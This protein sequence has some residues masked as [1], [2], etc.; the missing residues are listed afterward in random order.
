M[1]RK[2]ITSMDVA[3]KAGVSQS[4]V[5][6]V[7]NKKYNASFSRE[8]VEKVEAA[9]R[10]L[11]Y[12]LEKKAVKAGIKLKKTI[13]VVC[14]SLSNP[15]YNMLLEGIEQVAQKHNYDIFIC[16]TRRSLMTEEKYLKKV[17]KLLPSGMIY[18]SMPGFIQMV[19]AMSEKIPTVFVG[20]KNV[21]LNLDAIELDSRKPGNMVAKYLI[22]LGHN[23]V[24]YI[25]TPLSERQPARL[26]RMQ[27]FLEAFEAA[28]FKETVYVKST[29]LEEDER[30]QKTDMEFKTGYD[31]TLE[32]L[33]E[34]RAVTA[35]VGVND[36]VALGIR[37]ALLERRYKIP[38]DFSVV[39]CDNTLISGIR[40]I[41]L[42]TVDHCIVEKGAQACELVVEKIESAKKSGAS[43]VKH[44]MEYEPRLII[45]GSSAYPK[46]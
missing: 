11:G 13:I 21:D 46:Y 26:R 39:G 25:S 16:Q 29:A 34:G 30:F 10:E 33:D 43:Q 28:G 35:I 24:A 9:A 7:L 45:R 31:L 20:E 32:L 17:E 44:H 1:N 38:Q 40:G 12:S 2:M 4:T 15:Y 18:L 37:E 19:E 6:M 8:T 14:P 22:G 5:S 42:T 23:K 41:D 36:M 27:G 3:K